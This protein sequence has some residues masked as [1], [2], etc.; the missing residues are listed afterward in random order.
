M[1]TIIAQNEEVVRALGRLGI[2]PP[3]LLA[4]IRD[5][6]VVLD[7]ERRVVAI[8]GDWPDESP[9]RPQELRGKTLREMFGPHVAAVHEAAY[10]RALRG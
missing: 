10:A 1:S 6:I 3:E 2:G 5:E 9:R 4:S 7:R 8:L